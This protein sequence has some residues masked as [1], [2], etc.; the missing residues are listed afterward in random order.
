[1]SESK[2]A[3][4]VEISIEIDAPLEAV[5]KA[6]SEAEELTRWF[7]LE[8][9]VT[10][11]A[12]GSVW[13]S[14]G[15]PWE[16][17][18]KIEVWEPYR[19]LRTVEPPPQPDSIPVVVDY[20]L[21][22]HGGKT[23]L[24]LVH[25]FGTGADWEQEY[26]DSTSRGWGFMLANLRHYLERHPGTPRR[27]AWPRLRLALSP[28]ETWQRLMSSEGLLR[29]GSLDAVQP[30]SRYAIEAATGD[31]FEGEVRFFDPHRGFCATVENKEDALLWLHLEKLQQEYEIWLWLSAYGWPQSEV[32]AFRER[33][34]DTLRQLFP[35]GRVP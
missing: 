14:W 31:R 1:M 18:A 13:L 19:H 16:G 28:E 3:R 2:P 35:E 24:R 33:W 30:G 17:E 15:A 21:E 34:V 7:P 9:R 6:L 20:Y 29:H 23:V 32:N 5:W 11:G 4:T 25:S 26:Y 22:A 12:G 10:P 8:A 27:V